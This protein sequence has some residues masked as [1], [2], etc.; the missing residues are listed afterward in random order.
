MKADVLLNQK[1]LKE[2]VVLPRDQMK[3]VTDLLK[4]S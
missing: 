4:I 3:N 2:H 1:S